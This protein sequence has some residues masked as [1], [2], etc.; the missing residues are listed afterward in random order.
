MVIQAVNK[1][2]SLFVTNE[3]AVERKR[4]NQR[5]PHSKT[6]YAG[7]LNNTKDSITL[8]RQQAQKQAMK[9]VG[10]TFEQDKKID[11]N[12][13]ELQEKYEELKKNPE[14]NAKAIKSL[15][16]SI[17]NMK[18][19]RLKRSPML[20]AEKTADEIMEQ[21]SKDIIGQLRSEAVNYVDEKLQEVVEKAKEQAEKKEEQE[22]K[23][24]EQKEKKEELEKMVEKNQKADCE[25]SDFSSESKVTVDEYE[26]VE[27]MVSYN[28]DQNKAN[29]ELEKLMDELNLIM[30]DIKGAE[31]DVNL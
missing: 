11:E 3:N 6:I 26:N 12:M 25:E 7:N 18:Q 16:E 14:E 4:E 1:E 27:N 5:N 23:L 28:S 20:E 8:K 9:I 24:E 29:A 17:F 31:V 19:E 2:K 30:D 10:D 22:E 21:A 13:R 15:R